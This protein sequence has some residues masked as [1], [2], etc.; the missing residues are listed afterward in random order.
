MIVDSFSL[1]DALDDGFF[2]D[3]TIHS[4][5]GCA[6]PVHRV[7]LACSSP[8]VTYREWEVTLSAFKS[9]LVKVILE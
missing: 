2:S 3:L 5:D 1:K 4:S 9:P 8:K 7:V 6:F